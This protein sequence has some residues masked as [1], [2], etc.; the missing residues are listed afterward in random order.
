M[1]INEYREKID[2]IDDCIVKLFCD[3]MHVSADIARY[4]QSMGIAIRV[5]ER[6]DVKMADVAGK[7]DDDLRE[8]AKALYSTI[9]DA[10]CAYQEKIITETENKTSPL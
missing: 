6:E 2:R 9:I 5:P 1:D 3:R 8:Y 7:T 4:K 10:S